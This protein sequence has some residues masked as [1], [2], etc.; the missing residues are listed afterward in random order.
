M[1]IKCSKCG[2]EYSYAR[3]ICHICGDNL[4]FFGALLNGN[5]REYRWNCE[6]NSNYTV[7]KYRHIESKTG[8]NLEDAEYIMEQRIEREW[9][10]NSRAE[11]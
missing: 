10:S 5:R 9:N 8:I 6:K 2:L 7:S 4:I 11:I 3:N 1:L